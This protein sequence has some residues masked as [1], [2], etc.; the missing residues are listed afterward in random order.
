MV[1]RMKPC[2]KCNSNDLVCDS[3]WPD[4]LSVDPVKCLNCGHEMQYSP[5]SRYMF[6][7][8]I[9]SLCFGIVIGPLEYL[10]ALFLF[11]F[12]I[13][14]LSAEFGIFTDY[15]AKS[16]NKIAKQGVVLSIVASFMVG[17][18][19]YISGLTLLSGMLLAWV[20]GLW[21]YGI[22]RYFYATST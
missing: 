5:I 16:K 7:I 18:H 17:T 10:F 11:T 3:I 1:S 6:F 20:L 15:R 4:Y 19:L 12:I 22:W 14:G 9:S 8:S 2:T 21:L 13:F